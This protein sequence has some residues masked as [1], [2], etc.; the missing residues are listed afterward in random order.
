[1]YPKAVDAIQNLSISN[2]LRI[3]IGESLGLMVSKSYG[4]HEKLGG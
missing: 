2:D 1:M 3:L 4:A